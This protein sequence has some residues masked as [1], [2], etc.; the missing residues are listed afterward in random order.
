M[1]IM[2]W[3]MDQSPYGYLPA[4]YTPRSMSPSH[5]Q[6]KAQCVSLCGRVLRCM[7]GCVYPVVEVVASVLCC[8]PAWQ[9]TCS[10]SQSTHR[11]LNEAA[12]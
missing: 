4:S 9:Y 7:V 3:L 11:L 8:I 12:Q 1:H 10:D 5:A 2:Q 6:S